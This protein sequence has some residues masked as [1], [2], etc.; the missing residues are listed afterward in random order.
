MGKLI[1]ENGKGRQTLKKITSEQFNR[2]RE[3]LLRHCRDLE[4]DRFDY[5]FG[6]GS[7]DKVLKSLKEFQN[8]DGGFGHGIEPDFWLPKSSPMASW[9]AAQVLIEIGADKEEPIVQ[10]LISYLIDTYN[11]ESGQWTSVLPEN[12]DYPHAPWWH[13]EEGVQDNWSFNPSVEL[14][15]TLI[16]WSESTSSGSKIGWDSVGKAVTHLMNQ[17][18]MDKHEIN[19]FQQCIKL[20]KPHLST[21]ESHIPFS[22]E[23]VEEKVIDLALECINQDV[24]QWD[25]GYESLPLDFVQSPSDTLCSKLGSLIDQNFMFYVNQLS[26][27]G[28]WDISWEWGNYPKEFEMASIYWKGILAVERYKRFDSF[29][30]LDIDV[31]KSEMK[32]IRF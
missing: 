21:F 9:A 32:K 18:E 4:I 19:N 29:G 3:F 15:A 2:T 14:A 7:K 6:N 5:V 30:Y 12:N 31:E 11:E 13:W 25:T 24:T 16:H 23:Q 20:L 27:G 22:F 10:K 8:E 28:T 17:T 26:E 1:H